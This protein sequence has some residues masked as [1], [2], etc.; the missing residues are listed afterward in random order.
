M[1]EFASALDGEYARR[2][3]PEGSKDLSSALVVAPPDPLEKMRKL[4]LRFHG[5]V[6]QLRHC[7]EGRPTLDVQD[8]YD[9]QDLLHALLLLEF[10]DIR[11]EEWTP[12]YAGKS[13]RVDFL[14]KTEQIVVEVKKTRPGLGAKEVGDQLILDRERYSK[15]D[16]C[17]ALLCFVYD[18]EHRIANPG[19]LQADLSG[20][21]NGFRVEALVVPKSY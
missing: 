15:I 3:Q 11:P 7:R 16:G 4:L 21:V 14:L 18:P 6:V 1:N 13:S 10:D 19:G 5:V 8:E 17:H 12:S 20:L 2:T 9:V